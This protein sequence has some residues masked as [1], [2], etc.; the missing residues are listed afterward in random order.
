MVAEGDAPDGSPA[1]TSGLPPRR[2]GDDDALHPVRH[3]RRLRMGYPDPPLHGWELPA[4]R[5]ESEDGSGKAGASRRPIAAQLHE[6]GP[7][8]RSGRRW[9]RN[10]ARWSRPAILLSVLGLA[11]AVAA[12]SSAVALLT[13]GHPAGPVSSSVGRGGA[14]AIPAVPAAQ[15]IGDLRMFSQTA[16]WAQQLTDGSVLHTTQGVTRWTIASPPPVGQILAVA[17]VDA[18]TAR[19]ITAPRD[20]TADT[21]L[22]AWATQDGGSTWSRQGTLSVQGFNSSIGGT[23]DFLDA[24]HGWFSQV[25][26]AAGLAGTALFRTLDGGIH[27]SEVSATSGA[28]PP[29]GFGVIPRGC[30]ALTAAFL[31]ASTGWMT[32]TCVDGSTPLYVTRDGGLTWASAQ[33]AAPTASSGEETSFP[34]TFTSAAVGTLLIETESDAGVSTSVFATSDGGLSWQQRSTIVGA[35]LADDFLDAGHGWL[36]TDGD[37]EG[38]APDLHVTGDGGRTW[39]HLGAFPYVGLSLDF[40]TPEVGWA[41][42]D[43]GQL[44]SGSSYVVETTDGG[45]SW[46]A[47]LP[48]LFAATTSP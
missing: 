23:L 9:S 22:Q 38:S 31:S 27:W 41:A 7:P 26:A 10:P 4:S 5:G 43:H 1:D 11:A 42:A 15:G 36:V 30:D 46:T 25:E 19:A 35:P 8:T 48:R 45:R 47:V 6:A 40:L 13:Q 18:E 21:A 12:T 39:T 24:E 2:P 44:D 16:G 33:L 17:Y 14:S 28:V 37:G 32:G 34:P 20:S 3:L 29:G